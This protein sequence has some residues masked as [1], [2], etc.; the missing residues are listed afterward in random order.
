MNRKIIHL[1]SFVCFLLLFVNCENKQPQIQSSEKSIKTKLDKSADFIKVAL[2][3]SYKHDQIPRGVHSDGEIKFCGKGF[4]WTEGFFPGLCWN[5]YSYTKDEEFKKAAE[6]FQAKFEDHKYLTNNHDLG[7]VFNDSYGTA[8]RFVVYSLRANLTENT[9][10][11]H[12]VR[13]GRGDGIVKEQLIDN[14]SIPMAHHP[15]MV[16]GMVIAAL[17]ESERNP[18]SMT[19][20]HSDPSE[21]VPEDEDTLVIDMRDM[22]LLRTR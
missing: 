16:E 20:T 6:F 19:I 11:V 12:V 15:W 3:E 13:Q 22:V 1:F 21:P 9:R 18:K 2:H 8:Y 4:D 17:K 14:F 10:H 7:F 5:L